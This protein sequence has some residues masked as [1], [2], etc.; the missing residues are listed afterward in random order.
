MKKLY[1]P[2]LFAVLFT[3]GLQVQAQ[4][5]AS[6]KKLTPIEFSDRM[7]DITDSLYARGV[8]WGRHFN[9]AYKSK[10]FSSLKPYRVAVETF[11]VSSLS[12]VR[13]MLDVNDSKPLRMAM[14]EFLEFEQ[15][16]VIDG[17]TPMEKIKADATD[18]E[19]VAAYKKLEGLA[20]VE[21]DALKKVSTAQEAYAAANGFRIESEAEAEERKE[22]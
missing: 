15:K 10:N 17:F 21:G 9:E 4:K 14:I 12:N 7:S 13:S 1:A 5:A 20:S 3:M 18:E 11:I 22:N 19:V 16:M 8:A 2:I 6:S